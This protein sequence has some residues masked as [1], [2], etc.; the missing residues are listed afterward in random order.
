MEVALSDA[1]KSATIALSVIAVI[2]IVIIVLLVLYIVCNNGLYTAV[3]DI[4]V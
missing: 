1:Y 2:A 3:T 4:Q